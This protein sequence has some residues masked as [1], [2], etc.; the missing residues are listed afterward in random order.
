MRCAW[1]QA[2]GGR[3]LAGGAGADGVWELFELQAAFALMRAGI[4]GEPAEPIRTARSDRDF[5]IGAGLR[6]DEGAAALRLGGLPGHGA[7]RADDRLL[8]RRTSARAR[9][10]GGG[11]RRMAHAAGFQSVSWRD[12]DPS[13]PAPAQIPRYLEESFP[14][15]TVELLISGQGA[16]ERRRVRSAARQDI[17]RWCRDP[18]PDRRVRR[19]RQPRLAVV[20]EQHR[21]GTRSASCC[22]QRP[23]PPHFLP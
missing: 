19:V 5:Q 3:R 14:G 1:T 2:R 10:R 6:A 7:G 16:A 18:C 17:A 9:Q 23:R 8:N 13:P 12:R 20:D 11:V 4:A 22:A 21:F 15:L